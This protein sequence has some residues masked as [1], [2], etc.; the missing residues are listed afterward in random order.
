MKTF[1]HE[2]IFDLSIDHRT[3]FTKPMFGELA[4]YLFERHIL[5]LVEPTKSDRWDWHGV[6]VGTD[7]EHHASIQAQLPALM[8]MSSYESGFSSVR[9]TKI[10]NPLWKSWHAV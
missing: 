6:L 5:L 9:P 3:F 2:W 8:P 4:A 10:S 7:Y 1:K